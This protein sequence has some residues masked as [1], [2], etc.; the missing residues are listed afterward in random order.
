MLASDKYSPV[1][2]F[3]APRKNLHESGFP[4]SI[5]AN[6]CAISPLLI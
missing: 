4:R 3:V 5:G 1:Y 2:V 6:H